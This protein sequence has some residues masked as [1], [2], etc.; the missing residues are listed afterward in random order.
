MSKRN[1]LRTIISYFKLQYK[2]ISAIFNW[3]GQSNQKMRQIVRHISR[4]IFFSSLGIIDKS[5]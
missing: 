2:I 1:R 5:V 3:S 4:R